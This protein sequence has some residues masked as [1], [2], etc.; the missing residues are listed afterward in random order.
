MSDPGLD[1]CGCCTGLD[2]ETPARIDNPPGQS[3]IV[4]RSGTHAS[5]K[6]S[7]LARLS[8]SDLPALAGLTTRA[9]ADFTVAL[10]DALATTLDVLAFYQE[11]I[12]NE[13]F[14][15]TATERRSILELARLIG[16]ELAPGVAA[17]T[18]LAFSLQEVPG[19]PELAPEPVDIPVGTKVQSIPGP[20]EQPQ[21]FETVEIVEARA[22][23]NAIPVQASIVW[24]PRLGDRELWLA[25]VGSGLQPGDAIL[26]VGEE[27]LEVPG[28][29]RWDIRLVAQIDEDRVLQRT[30]L[31]WNGPLGHVVP[32][33]EPAASGASVYVFCQRAGLF[34]H[35]APDPRLM[36]PSQTQL[37][38][39][40]EGN[41]AS[42]RWKDTLYSIQGSQ[43]DLDAAYPKITP[44]SWFALVSNAAR[45]HPS[46]LSGY[47]ELYR[48]NA[49]SFPSRTDFG[50]SSKIT[51]LTPDTAENLDEFRHRLREDLVLAQSEELAVAERPLRYPLY[52]DGLALGRLAPDIG[53]GRA[54]ALSG[55]RARIGLRKGQPSATLQLT[56][57]GTSTLEEGD[58]LRLAAAPELQA[59]G[60]WLIMPPAQFGQVM[61]APG[62]TV[63]RLQL[64]DRDGS[65]G[66]LVIAASAIELQPAGDKDATVQEIALVSPLATAVTQDRDR[67][68]FTLAAPLKY[69]Y[70]RDTTV[71]NA[72]VARA[73]HGETVG[74]IVGS[75]D[76]RV[77]NASFVLRQAPLTY[78]S[79]P[80]PS[81][82]SSTLELRVNDLLWQE[83]PSLFS[84]GP[85][86]RVYETAID[87][88]SVTTLRFGDGIEGARPPSGD[89]NIRARYRKGLG[90]GGNVAA[91]K[92][93]NLLTRPLGVS[94]TTNPE[95]ANGGEDPE[96]ESAAR[97]NAPLTVL[98][99]DRAVS[100]R[101]YRDFAR[102]FAGI[103]KAHALWIPSGAARG[104]FLTIAGEN[105]AVVPVG[106]DTYQNLLASLRR[107]GDPLMPLTLVGYRDARFR[108]R[109]TVKVAADAE[110]DLVLLAV[111]AALRGAFGFAVRDFGQGVSV[112]EVA[113]VAQGVI[114]VEAV[115]VVELHRGDTPA[116]SFVPRLFAALPLASPTAAPL[117]AELLTLDTG[118]LQLEQMP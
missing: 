102:A 90:L 26:I 13:N 95:P 107:Y 53:P 62:N 80:T 64:L 92:L 105:G 69:V 50:L 14:L 103:A 60:A 33:I 44:D 41:G 29:E 78:V 96:N 79:A 76:S 42:L 89:H 12:A 97:T 4:Y 91:G 20:G 46:G 37:G 67:T 72:N 49:V 9:D 35:N 93:S 28:S 110:A 71:V 55:K 88:Q 77:P 5:F 39:L 59:G 58:T 36:S 83:V 25:G 38:T 34:G 104:V 75:A 43:I 6:A 32:H 10:S 48:A 98:T 66:S 40:I 17:S 65:D 117:P 74:E 100:I 113:A 30:R 18:F 21:T 22:E 114:G 45:P 70:D 106:G 112:D 63:L 2:A 19:S 73:T 118:P 7:L 68:S 81:G 99:L 8:A 47:V 31:S 11:R 56:E 57:G 115:Q 101:D 111:E 23:W 87:D 1:T 15:R 61:A 109:L 84:H 24:H 52:G 16:Y 51:R 94:G 85:A 86:E 82:R 27:R 116:P 3:S 54:L 108:C